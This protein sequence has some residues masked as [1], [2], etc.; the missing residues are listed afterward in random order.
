MRNVTPLTLVA[1]ALA[2]CAAPRAADQTFAAPRSVSSSSLAV[3][4]AYAASFTAIEAALD[5]DE[6]EV[7]RSSIRQLRSRL[8]SDLATAPTL[9]EARK[10][11]DEIALLTV[12]GD[13]PSRESV[14]AALAMADGF[15]RIVDGR[16]RIASVELAVDLVRVQG[17]EEVEVVLSGRSD[18]HEPLTVRPSAAS[19]VVERI[20]L[21][22]RTGMEQLSS[23]RAA[24]P[25]TPELELP[26]RGEANTVVAVLPIQVPTGAIA[27]RMRVDLACNGGTIAEDG[28]AFPA[29]TIEVA[30]G[31]RTDIPAWIPAG[32]VD[33]VELVDVVERGNAPLAL[34]LECA[35]RIQPSRRD[36]ALDRLGYA[37][38]TLPLDS[39][40]TLVPALRWLVGTDEF[41]RNERAWRDWLVQRYEARV[42]SGDATSIGTD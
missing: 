20:S 37:V 13:L 21:E 29:R 9:A 14:E 27:T 25:D 23:G 22:P 8:E 39:M 26:A 15:E 5:E 34:V 6:L 3:H 36:E 18:W 11:D 28:D 31:E 12:S 42:A 33:P 40:R 4:R 1:A 2:A 30:L 38:Q 7:A 19:I 41:G 10:R 35:V 24:L 16:L 32:V 17:A